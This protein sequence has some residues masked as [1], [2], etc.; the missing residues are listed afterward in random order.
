MDTQDYITDMLKDNGKWIKLIDNMPQ[1]IE[2]NDWTLIRPSTVNGL[3]P[4]FKT[5]D[6]RYFPVTAKYVVKLLDEHK[7][8]GKHVK[9]TITRFNKDDK[10]KVYAL[11]DDISFL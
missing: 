1:V 8:I 5:K 11:L 2:I 7:L 4:C 6:G 9:F 3:V 10:D